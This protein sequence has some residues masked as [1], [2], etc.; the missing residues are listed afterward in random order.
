VGAY[1]TQ[2]STSASES[3]NQ[4]YVSGNN[5]N[6]D[7]GET[8]LLYRVTNYYIDASPNGMIPATRKNIL[9]M[10]PK[11]EDKIR[12]FMKSKNTNLNK[13]KDVVELAQFLS[14]L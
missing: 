5:L 9:T 10:Y 11:H 14:Q 8:L 2:N 7:V 12:E 1:G 3:A 4:M 13:D 6:L